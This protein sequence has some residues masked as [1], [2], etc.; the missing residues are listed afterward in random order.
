MRACIRATAA[1]VVLTI[2]GAD[3]AHAQPAARNGRVAISVNAGVQPSTISF[4]GST[5]Q[6][7]YLETSVLD[8]TYGVRNGLLV[9]GGVRYRIA[10]DFGVGVAVSWFSTKNDATVNATL[11]HPFFFRT[12]R[13]IEGTATGLR[14]EEMVTH[15]QATYAI[16]P[17]TRLEVIFAGGPSFFRAR[18]ALVES[19]SYTDS[20]PYE[21]PVM[22][23]ASSTRIR[24]HKT[25]FNAGAD[26]GLRLSRRAGVGGLVRFSRA[27]I[28]FVLPNGGATVASDAGGIQ[29]AGGVRVYF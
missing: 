11:P 19:V 23:A 14:R 16:R 9:D 28:P 15:L 18:Q 1:I 6:P 10:G 29:V 21:A 17:S 27:R 2:A 4:D 3:R 5:T 26:V 25:G 8:T 12:P 20:Y 7:V 22:T 24:G 13:S